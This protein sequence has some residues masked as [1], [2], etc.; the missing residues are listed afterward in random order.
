VTSSFD[1]PVRAGGKSQHLGQSVIRPAIL[2]LTH[3]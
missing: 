3:F 2:A 1:H